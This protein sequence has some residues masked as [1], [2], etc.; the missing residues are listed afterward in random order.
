MKLLAKSSEKLKQL[1]DR[2]N[3]GFKYI[4]LQLTSDFIKED[5]DIKKYLDNILNDNW[6]I[7]SIQMPIIL[8]DDS[9]DIEY[10]TYPE[11]EKIFYNCC[12]LAQKAAEYYNKN[13]TVVIHNGLSL[14]KYKKM[15]VLLNNI[16]DILNKALIE[17]PNIDISIE[18]YLPFAVNK[19]GITLT[20]FCFFENVELVKYLNS[21]CIRKSFYTTLDI[22]NTLSTIGTL[23]LFHDIKESNKF[24][25]DIEE[26]F[27]KNKDV[28]NNIHLNNIKHLGV[29]K[30]NNS[31]NFDENNIQDM[32]LLEHIIELYNKYEYDCN[33]VLEITELSPDDA[34]EAEKLFKII[35]ENKYSIYG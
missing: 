8:D 4:E 6:K 31:V 15:P 13:V 10:L 19:K 34:V 12:L 33:V 2:K 11:N 32:H 28:I 22:C 24:I 29:G 23:E 21:I 27:K 5:V 9:I 16:I 17:N 25:V 3:K 30:G 18:N 35:K 7:E 26:Y 14:E 1:N 20:T